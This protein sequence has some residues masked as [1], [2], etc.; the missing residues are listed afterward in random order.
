MQAISFG[1]VF[2]TTP[3]NNAAAER[4]AKQPDPTVA[5]LIAMTPRS[6]SSLLC[7]VMKGTGRL[8]KPGER[9]ALPLVRQNIVRLAPAR[10][11][12]EYLRNILKASMTPNGVSGMKAS[13]FQFDLFRSALDDE[14][15]VQ[16][17][18]YIHL[19][20]RD[21]A[22]QA[23]SLYKATSSTV[24]HT[25]KQHSS[26]AVAQL[27]S[28]EYDYGKLE[29]WHH[30]LLRQEAGWVRYFDTHRIV[31]LSISYED[32]DNDVKA[33]VRRIANYLGLPLVDLGLN[34]LETVFSKLADRQ[35]IEW[36]SRFRLERDS[37]QRAK[38]AATPP[39]V[40]A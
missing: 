3:Y 24:F 26:Q 27:Q 7:D 34:R 1:N 16:G 40:S 32:I 33:V 6:G 5:Y 35:S 21:L 38:Q 12:D 14:S 18:R 2:T 37:I 4:L 30:H 20:R 36:A 29:H 31:P 11:C 28:L 17:L 15:A 13:W 9:L 19:T 22:N 8:G 25:N 23:V 39:A 10:N